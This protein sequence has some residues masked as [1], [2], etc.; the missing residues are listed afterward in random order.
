MKLSMLTVV[1]Q[2]RRELSDLRKARKALDITGVSGLT[3]HKWLD[4]FEH[5][6]VSVLGA[7]VIKDG[8]IRALDLRIGEVVRNIETHG[9]DVDE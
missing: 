8:L 5:N 2:H 4:G 6:F 3:C 1:Q 9:I 7:K